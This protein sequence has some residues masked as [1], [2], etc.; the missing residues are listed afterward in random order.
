MSKQ[1][2]TPGLARPL[3]GS[4]LS[5]AILCTPLA[6]ATFLWDGLGANDNL[7]TANNWNPNAAPPSNATD[8]ILSFAGTTRPTPVQ[9]FAG[10]MRVQSIGF[11]AAAG[12]F[13][14]SGQ[15][16][17]FQ[18][19][20]AAP[21]IAVTTGSTITFANQ[22][23]LLNDTT[24]TGAGPVNFQGSVTGIGLLTKSNTGDVVISGAV[25]IPSLTVGT[26][27][28]IFANGSSSSAAF[29]RV[30]SGAHLAIQGGNVNTGAGA[31]FQVG[32]SAGVPVATATL[33]SGSITSVESDIGNVAGA[34]GTMTQSGG[35]H[36]VSGRLFL[37]VND[38]STGN[39]TLSAGN[40]TTGG[41]T[42]GHMGVGNFTQSGG[43]HSS[44]GAL[45]LGSGAF[46]A[47]GTYNLDG[48]TLT[49]PSISNNAASGSTS[50]FNFNGGTLRPN[51]STATFMTGLTAA[52]VQAGGARIDTLGSNITIP[53]PLIHAAALG[54]NPDGGL[55]K[56]G[57]GTLTLTG[58]NTYTGSTMVNAGTLELATGGSITNSFVQVAPGGT[59]LVSGGSFNAG[60][61]GIY[62]NVGNAA[63]P[64]PATLNQ[65]AGSVTATASDIGNVAGGTGIY[66][67]SGGTHTIS[68]QMTVGLNASAT[69][70]YNLSGTGVVN[71]ELSLIGVSGMGTVNQTGGTFNAVRMNIGQF[72]NATGTYKLSGGQFLPS[73]YLA[74]G[75]FGPGQVQQSGGSLVTAELVM[76]FSPD[77]MGNYEISGGTLTSPAVEVGY[78]GPATMV[79][80]GG[81]VNA[82][83]RLELGSTAT[84]VGSYILR[85]GTLRPRIIRG[86]TGTGT[87]SFDGGTVLTPASDTNFIT[88][89]DTVQVLEGGA[90]IDTNG[91]N[92]TIVPPILHNAGDPSSFTVDGG[93]TKLGAGTLTLSGANTFNGGVTI[94][95]GTLS[96]ANDGNLGA[97]NRPVTINNGASLL[98]PNN[99]TTSARTFN[100]NNASLVPA[101][102]GTLIYGGATVNGGFLGFNGTSI[103]RLGAGTIVNFTTVLPGTTVEQQS[104]TSSLNGVTFSGTLNQSSGAVLNVSSGYLSPA[105]NVT[106]GGTMNTSAVEST[107]RVTITGTLSN[108][109]TSLVLGYGSQTTITASGTL[110][111]V[112][113][114]SIELN[115]AR[116]VNSGDQNGNLNINQGSVV[117]GSGSFG[118]VTVKDGGTFSPG[119]SPGTANLENF[120]LA[121]GGS[122]NFELNSILTNPGVNQDFLNIASTF[123]IGAATPGNP[124]VLMITSLLPNNNAG[125]VTNFANNVP[126]TFTLATAANT[127]VGFAPDKFFIDTSPF[128]NDLDGGT[129]SLALNGNQRSLLLSFTPVPEPGSLTLLLAA[130]PIVG[131]RFR[132]RPPCRDR[133]A[134]ME[135]KIGI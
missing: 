48:G 33:S 119:N 13:S 53:Q 91:N 87:F 85:G 46:S 108:T 22:V 18:T 56:L 116:L 107:G 63:G 102:N 50:T 124:I 42:V 77:S 6:A 129:F 29:I 8:T 133:S 1:A 111:A 99:F 11:A 27:S 118:T 66:N 7:S 60:P 93:L 98:V 47:N 45:H 131:R 123:T 101:A 65:T 54:S 5:A 135:M 110:T 120:S 134:A 80:T 14:F 114:S 38:T 44:T 3:V 43:S 88:N 64:L 103:H 125:A 128:L 97:A 20:T 21:T 24:I 36:T 115:G 59:F 121:G 130:W 132:R 25:S 10:G 32:N 92:I 4:I 71:A 83:V 72:A 81:L 75:A 15:K 70:V 73:V 31:F 74:V 40:L 2:P 100:L 112:G 30:N 9:D 106:V 55:T 52:N 86:L 17:S 51:I 105:A 96:V 35:A 62:L 78:G 68:T 82:T 28:L 127:V 58:A 84:G 19:G 34:T 69:G 122:Y 37:G 117:T 61:N 26:G 41:T 76:A 109:G 16:F 39:Y 23:E 12:A 94:S 113:T 49:V 67:H 126:Y 89:V 95:A 79:Q 104:G 90:K 57:N